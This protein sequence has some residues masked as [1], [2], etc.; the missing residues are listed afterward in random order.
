[1]KVLVVEDELRT[2]QGLCSLI[3]QIDPRLNIVGEAENG[4]EGLKMIHEYQPDLVFTDIKM[5]FMDGLTM[6][7]EA[8]R[9]GIKLTGIILSGFSEFSLA[10]RAI[11]IS[12]CDYLLKPVSVDDLEKLLRRLLPPEV[13]TSE[14]NL[15]FAGYSPVIANMVEVIQQ[16]YG[17]RLALDSFA[18]Q[19]K[20]TPEYLSH[21]F[22]KETGSTY[23]EYIKS[24]RMEEAKRCL[25]ETNMKIYEIACRVG[26]TEA[27]Y[28]S[29]AF[30]DYAGI[31]PKQFV[32]SMKK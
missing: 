19:Y 32:I 25:L 3:E 7:E 10:Q 9:A 12:V 23:T 20:V 5:P 13:E 15:Q 24:V 18:T 6:L 1:M 8:N 21:L 14:S 2:R 27:N 30:R 16:C 28:F 4:L 22:A 11:K 29:K 26:Y 17:Q 31:S